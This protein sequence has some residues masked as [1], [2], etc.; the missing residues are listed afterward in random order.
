ML[1]KIVL[2]KSA[3]FFISFNVILNFKIISM[4]FIWKTKILNSC[5]VSNCK[6]YLLKYGESHYTR[7]PKIIC[8]S[9][10]KANDAELQS[11]TYTFIRFLARYLADVSKKHYSMFERYN[12]N[13]IFRRHSLWD[14]KVLQWSKHYAFI[15]DTPFNPFYTHF[16]FL[17]PI[18]NTEAL[19]KVCLCVFWIS[20]R[21][22]S[23][24]VET[25]GDE[26]W[27][28]GWLNMGKEG[29]L[30]MGKGIPISMQEGGNGP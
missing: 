26:I 14:L 17:T 8:G 22:T 18:D 24:R 1:P 12:L 3:F 23:K 29:W 7:T 30:N 4:C 6:D 5:N 20:D 2:A 27:G 10:R 16:H 21:V 15:L 28:E 25:K 19:F 13:L 9:L 11:Y